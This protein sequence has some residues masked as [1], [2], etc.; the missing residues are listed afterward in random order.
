MGAWAS[1]TEPRQFINCQTQ[2]SFSHVEYSPRCMYMDEVMTGIYSGN[3]LQIYCG[4][5]QV[6]CFGR[7]VKSEQKAQ[8]FLHEESEIN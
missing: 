8:E 2:I 7:D 4:R 5:V 3:P 1:D 6:N